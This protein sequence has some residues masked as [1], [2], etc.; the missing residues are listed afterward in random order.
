[1]YAK[2]RTGKAFLVFLCCFCGGWV[3]WNLLPWFPHFDGSDFGRLTTILSL[4][5]S[6]ATSVLMA[7]GEKQDELQRKQLL[8]ILHLMEAL[9]EHIGNTTPAASAVVGSETAT[10]GSNCLVGEG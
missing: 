10:Q 4:E 2:L 7:A 6:I 9:H 3:A 1:M 5:A 8:Y